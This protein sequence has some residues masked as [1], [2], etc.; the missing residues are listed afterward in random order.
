MHI[1]LAPAHFQMP[2]NIALALRI[3]THL[4]L[5]GT[6][7]SLPAFLSAA[8]WEVRAFPAHTAKNTL[9]T[10]YFPSGLSPY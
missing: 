5:P 1:P 3:N 6:S 8:Q 10:E 2:V 7:A 4:H 9:L